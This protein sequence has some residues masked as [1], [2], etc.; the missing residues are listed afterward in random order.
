MQTIFAAFLLLATNGAAHAQVAISLPR[1]DGAATPVIVYDPPGTACP[2]LALISPGAGGNE[3]AMAYLAQAFAHD[4]WRAIVLGHRESGMQALRADIRRERGIRRGVQ[5]LVAD[6]DAYRGRFMDIAA[7]LAWSE[8]RCHAPFKALLGHSMGARTVMLDAGA[9][10]RLGLHAS[11]AFDAYVAMSPPPADAIFPA[12]AERTV[13]APML[14]LTGT[15]DATLDRRDYT[16]RIRGF[17]SLGS[18]CAW[19]GVI[20][21]ASHMNFA[22]IGFGSK[23]ATQSATIALGTAFL[24]ALRHGHCGQPPVLAGVVV[25][26][27]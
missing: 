21:G 4:G 20:S 25:T 9:S 18:S 22:G 27:K 26:S 8:R 3:K 17:R 19:L 14:L 23:A 11:H 12:A 6:P 1:A 24:D 2:P 7:A 13:S 16:A 10:N 5:E 15:R